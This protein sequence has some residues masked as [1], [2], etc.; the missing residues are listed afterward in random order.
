MEQ[1]IDTVKVL[2]PALKSKLLVVA[3]NRGNVNSKILCCLLHPNVKTLDLSECTISDDSIRAIY[4]CKHLYK[5]DLNPGR[6]QNREISTTGRSNQ[7]LFSFQ[8]SICTQYWFFI[9]HNVGY[10]KDVQ[11]TKSV[12]LFILL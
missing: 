7:L 2:P 11:M 3:C 4:K 8:I 6:N 1:Y 9:K 5:L 12:L 10:S